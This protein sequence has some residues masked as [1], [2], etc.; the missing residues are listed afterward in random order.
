MIIST[1]AQTFVT[2]EFTPISHHADGS[3]YAAE[4]RLRRA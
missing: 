4:G 2:G 1:D 3:I